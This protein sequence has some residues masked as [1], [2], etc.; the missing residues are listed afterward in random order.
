MNL[1]VFKLIGFLSLL[2]VSVAYSDTICGDPPP[3][4]N[5][6]LKGEIEGKA[7]LLS[8]FIG[9]ANLSGKIETSRTEIFS[10]Y[11]DAEKS[12]ANA[13]FDYQVCVLIMNDKKLDTIQKLN[14]LK[15]I[16][17][18]FNNSISLEENQQNWVIYME[19]ET[20]L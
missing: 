11:P 9:D 8:R 13:F 16:K 15:K 1:T 7:Q 14:E 17:R 18:E 2:S 6:A 10:K 3:V 12:R 4:A 19:T 20:S 5:E